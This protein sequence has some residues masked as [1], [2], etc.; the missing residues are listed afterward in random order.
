MGAGV[1]KMLQNFLQST[2]KTKYVKSDNIWITYT[3]DVN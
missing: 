1:Q 2:W 3:D